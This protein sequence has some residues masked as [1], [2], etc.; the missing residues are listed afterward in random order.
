M[1]LPPQILPERAQDRAL[2]D[3]LIARAFG[4]GRHSKA[5]ERLREG[6]APELEFSRV[7]L[8][9]E[10]LVGAV[11][12]WTITIGD[13]P[14]LFLGPIA[15]ERDQRRHGVGAALVERACADAARA[16]REMILLVGDPPFFEPL[17]FTAR[18]TGAVIMPG[19]VDRRR[20]MIR[21][22]TASTLA[23]PAGLVAP[24]PAPAPLAG[25]PAP[26]VAVI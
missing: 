21:R 10:R 15:V 24:A 7:A 5:A 2:V 16:G 25:A 17:G 23:P 4:P 9:G 6:R 8:A 1:S 18:D 3:A 14:A 22:L 11:R 20:V 12:V 19:P 13:R 26:L